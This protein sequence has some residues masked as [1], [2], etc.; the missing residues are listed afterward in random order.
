MNYRYYQFR[1]KET[2]ENLSF[3]ETVARNC[4]IKKLRIKFC[5]SSLPTLF[6]KRF[7]NRCISV[8]LAKFFKKPILQNTCEWLVLDF[9][10]FYISYS[11]IYFI[12][13]NSKKGNFY[14]L[15]VFNRISNRR[16][17]EKKLDSKIQLFVIFSSKELDLK[18][19]IRV[20]EPA[21][22]EWMNENLWFTSTNQ[23]L[24][25]KSIFLEQICWKSWH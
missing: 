18:S 11:I 16:T 21:W 23:Q 14:F 3:S 7:W 17:I 8:N 19:F 1:T 13:R 9:A 15:I 2:K 10:Q 24:A 4:S 5:Q 25:S 20:W 6:K 22:N 12:K